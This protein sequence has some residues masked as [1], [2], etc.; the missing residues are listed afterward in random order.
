MYDLPI[1]IYGDPDPQLA[2]RLLEEAQD[3]ERCGQD[4]LWN[5]NVEEVSVLAGLFNMTYGKFR[6][7]VY[8]TGKLP[9]IKGE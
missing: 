3:R 6:G 8:S 2:S 1:K 9:K 7:Y 5:M 4:P